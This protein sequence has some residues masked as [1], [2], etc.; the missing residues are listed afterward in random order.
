MVVRA[1]LPLK[2]AQYGDPLPSVDPATFGQ[3]DQGTTVA[4]ALPAADLQVPV[5]TAELVKAASGHVICTL[6]A[7]ADGASTTRTFTVPIGLLTLG[8]PYAVTAT[9]TASTPVDP[10]PANDSATRT[11]TIVTSLIINCS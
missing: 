1:L 8:W 7:L 5:F 11:C 9:R 2:L 10:N 3:V 6:G 4:T